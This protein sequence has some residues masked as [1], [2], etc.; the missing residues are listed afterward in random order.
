[1]LLKLTSEDEKYGLLMVG[2]DQNFY[3]DGPLYDLK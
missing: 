3:K 2:T 1:M